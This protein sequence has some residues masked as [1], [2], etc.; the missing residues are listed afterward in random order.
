MIFASRQP[1]D[2]VVL[3]AVGGGGG[4]RPIK[5]GIGPHNDT[6]NMPVEA[7]EMEFPIVVDRLEYNTD[8][9]G[10]GKYRG[11]LGVRKDYRAMVDLLVG[12]HSNRHRIPAPGLLGGMPGMVTRYVIDA[13]SDAPQRV[14][15]NTSEIPL[16]AGHCMS[17]ITGGGGYGDPFE[18]EQ[19]QVLDDVANGIVSLQAAERDY[20]VVLDAT[21][22]S[23]DR[24]ATGRRRQLR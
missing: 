11:G 3:E 9:G 5:D 10:A 6:V 23:I 15:R 7:M 20:G 12:G 17:V 14:P 18:R 16:D 4:A 19:Q 24:L 2:F 8:S 22:T 13:D 1:P 21:G